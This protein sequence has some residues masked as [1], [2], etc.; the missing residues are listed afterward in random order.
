VDEQRWPRYGP[1]LG[2]GVSATGYSLFVIFKPH[3]PE[4]ALGVIFLIIGVALVGTG[5]WLR[6]RGR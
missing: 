1:W 2:A 3:S 4:V 5:L 6:H